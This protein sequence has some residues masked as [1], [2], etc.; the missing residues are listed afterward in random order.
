MKQLFFFLL[1]AVSLQAQTYNTVGITIANTETKS[2]TYNQFDTNTVFEMAATTDTLF[3]TEILDG[4]IDV[5]TISY[6]IQQIFMLHEE[7]VCTVSKD[8]SFTFHDDYVEMT[9]ILD[10]VVSVRRFFNK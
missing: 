9:L 2:S 1:F 3:I 10:K 6:P 8:L 5:V 7:T 4:V